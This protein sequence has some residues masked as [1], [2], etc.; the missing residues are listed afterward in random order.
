MLSKKES[1][2]CRKMSKTQKTGP[3]M[4]LASCCIT[5][6]KFGQFPNW[7]NIYMATEMVLFHIHMHAE[8]NQHQI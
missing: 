4:L 1:L 7:E 8:L 2:S 3:Q 6:L 5:P